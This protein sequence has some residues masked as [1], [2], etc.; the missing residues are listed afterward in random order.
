L[1]RSIKRSIARTTIPDY[2]DCVEKNTKSTE[3]FESTS[4]I[5][6]SYHWWKAWKSIVFYRDKISCTQHAIT[7]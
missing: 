6:S 7:V 4:G 3:D 1:T 2:H 5:H